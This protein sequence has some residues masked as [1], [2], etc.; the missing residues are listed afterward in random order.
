[1]EVS[2][3]AEKDAINRQKHGISLA[4]TSDFDFDSCL[5]ILDDSQDYG[6]VRMRAI[7]FLDGRLYTL[8]FSPRGRDQIRAINLRKSSRQESREYAES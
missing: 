1:V 3:G 6:E 4:R 5:Y 8:V 2:F 7:G